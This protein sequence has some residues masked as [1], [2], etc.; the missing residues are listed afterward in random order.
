MELDFSYCIIRSL[1]F[2]QEIKKWTFISLS[3]CQPVSFISTSQVMH[4]D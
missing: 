2:V 1:Y 3:S 4:F